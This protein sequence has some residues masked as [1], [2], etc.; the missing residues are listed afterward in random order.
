MYILSAMYLIQSV[1]KNYKEKCSGK[2]NL[3]LCGLV[4]LLGITRI[5]QSCA[6]DPSK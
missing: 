2:S 3:E 1:H 4:Y 6:Y 5:Q